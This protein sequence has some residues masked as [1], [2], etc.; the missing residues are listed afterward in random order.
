MR[1]SLG[2]TRELLVTPIGFHLFS[3]VSDEL[4]RLSRIHTDNIEQYRKPIDW[5]QDLH[6]NTP[7]KSFLGSLSENS[8]LD[9]LK[10]LAAFSKAD[11]GTLEKL[12]IEKHNLNTTLLQEEIRSLLNQ[13]RELNAI[14]ERISDYQNTFSSSDWPKMASHLSKIKEL[15]QTEQKGLAEIAKERG[16]EFFDSSEFSDFV[17]AA[18]EYIKK[19]TL[20]DYP[21]NEEER[22]IY[23]RQKLKDQDS[24]ELLKSYRTLLNDPTQDQLKHFSSAL[25]DLRSALAKID[26][27]IRLYQ[28]SFGSDEEQNPVQPDFLRNY[29]NSVKTVKKV[30]DSDDGNL[31]QETP[32]NVDY[33]TVTASLNGR[34]ELIEKTLDTKKGVLATIEQKQRELDLKINELLDR[35]K[36]QSKLPETKQLLSGLKIAHQLEGYAHAFNTES[37]SRKTSEARKGLIAESFKGLFQDELD[38]LRRSD[39]KVNL[40]FKT[41]KATS[42]IIQDIGSVYALSDILSEGEQKTIALAEFLAE[43]QLDGGT[44]PVV[45]DDPVTS[46]D[47]KITDEVARRLVF[48]S[49]SRQVI[50]FT[51]SILFLNSIKHMSELARFKGLQ[52]KYFET[53]VDLK[54]TGF[55]TETPT[56][57]D[58]TF[59]F[60]KSKINRILNLP[61]VEQKA[62][63]SELAI[64][65]YNYL[66]PAIEVFVEKEMF[67]ETIKRYRKNVALTSIEKIN[68]A[69]IDK[70]KERLFDIFEKCCEYIDAHSSPDD[71][72]SQP[73]LGELRIDFDSVCKIREEF[74]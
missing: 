24:R 19:M 15:K 54:N 5:L 57:K 72:A 11:A 73:S 30:A 69:L 12:E 45:F 59:K 65:G 47:H 44:G 48:L 71:I 27:E 35:R 20:H 36:L 49:K 52:F 51:H 16:V 43:L 41:E 18:D 14:N 64:N 32:F 29:C 6:E 70:H 42:L 55:L 46:L 4:D 50:V 25:S 28:P 56:P 34:A 60:Y 38:G 23:C 2:S 66:R 61:E 22:C 21:E 33:A 37:I 39:I 63:A 9:Q 31:I 8:S 40:D 3:L 1:I 53:T 26:D 7:I 13:L 58:E 17:K 67:R 68:G 74:L 10:T 62:R